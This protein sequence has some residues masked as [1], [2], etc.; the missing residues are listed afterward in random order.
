MI[1]VVVAATTREREILGGEGATRSPSQLAAFFSSLYSYSTH[2]YTHNKHTRVQESGIAIA[3]IDQAPELL[4][5]LLLLFEVVVRAIDYEDAES[6]ARH[7]LFSYTK[8]KI[9]KILNNNRLVVA[10]KKIYT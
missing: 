3:S 4:L 6:P 10:E 1:V 9:K 2:T 7:I 8:Q 5:L